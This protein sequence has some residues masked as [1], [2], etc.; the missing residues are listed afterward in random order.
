MFK[1]TRKI[2]ELN[3]RLNGLSSLVHRLEEGIMHDDYPK[4]FTPDNCG[5]YLCKHGRV[6]MKSL[7]LKK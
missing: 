6:T 4:C 1:N 5:F 2:N 3:E 7:K